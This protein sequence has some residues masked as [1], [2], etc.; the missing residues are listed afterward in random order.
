MEPNGVI[1][2]KGVLSILVDA[3]IQGY[4]AT[5]KE[6]RLGILLGKLQ[7]DIAVVK[8]AS[9]YRGGDRSRTSANVNPVRFTQRVRELAKK[10]QSGFLG[11][12]HTHNEVA[13]TITSAMSVDDRQH[14]CSDPPHIVELIVAIWGSD[15]PSR[16]SQRYLQGK[17]NGYRYRI[18][19]YQMCSPFRVIPVFSRDAG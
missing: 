15:S 10:H 13:N 9:I 6:E 14:L 4:E 3:A 1:L 16:Q 12:F 2:S 8:Y 19:G 11:T 18:A 17:Y 5:Y 7:N